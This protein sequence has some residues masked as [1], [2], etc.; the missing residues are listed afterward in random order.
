MDLETFREVHE[1]WLER[2]GL[3]ERTE[4]GRVATRKAYDLYGAE[5]EAGPEA[6]EESEAERRRRAE[7]FRML[8]AA[9][10]DL[11]RSA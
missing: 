3:L 9:I 8:D 5:A 10:P 2:S 1:P 11:W 4:A 7:V 6:A